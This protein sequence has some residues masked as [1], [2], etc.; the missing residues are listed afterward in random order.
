MTGPHTRG[1]LEM[2][3]AMVVSG[4]IG[5]F[6]VTSGEP[7]VDVVFW[8]CLFAL[9]A[10]VAI[11][12]AGGHLRV[13]LLDRR[14]LM[15]AIG[16]G[17]ALVLNWLA[18]FSAYPLAS[19][20]VA[21]IVYNVQPFLLVGLGLAFLNEPISRDRLAWL[22]VAFAG[23][24]VMTLGGAQ[25]GSPT[26]AGG[27]LLGIFLSLAA[28]FFYAL[29]ALAA[30]KL[31]GTPPQL[32]AL[33]QVATGV[34]MLAPLADW[35]T[36]PTGLGTW[37]VLVTLG[38]VHTGLMY[39]LLYGAIQKLPVALT[40]TLSFLYPVVAVAVDLF[41]FGHVLTLTQAIGGCAIL[42]AA[43]ATTLNWSPFQLKTP[44]TPGDRP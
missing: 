10:L 7:P 26:G 20:S 21:T 29:A 11:C 27:Y 15:L 5:W 28:A 32:I 14:K 35:D 9:P 8:R 33:I 31:R 43:I 3:A 25:I 16:G 2:T 36:L 17:V 22:A 19:I 13:L 41:A 1:I 12:L 37:S 39:A 38:F 23:T 4:T 18:L 42:F 34:L 24:A 44:A 30:R 6:V 40:G